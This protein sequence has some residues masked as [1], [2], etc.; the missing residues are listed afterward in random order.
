MRPDKPEHSAPIPAL[1][2]APRNARWATA[3]A[4]AAAISIPVL[5]ALA[6][7]GHREKRCQ[8]ETQECLDRLATKLR[9]KAWA[10][11]DKAKTDDGRIRVDSIAPG[12]PAA[13]AGLRAG[14]VILA[15]EGVELRL[16]AGG[17]AE[18]HRL[19]KSL[20]PGAVVRYQVERRGTVQEIAV[21]LGRIP[22][23]QIAE[24]VGRHLLGQH[25]GG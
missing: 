20:V 23:A 12:G 1:R 16:D 15:I 22:E 18:L 10:G 9:A 7:D 11:F 13:Q 6:G 24:T 17:K 25:L 19:Q 4:L 3:L 5:P 14:D 8:A 21:T 2:T